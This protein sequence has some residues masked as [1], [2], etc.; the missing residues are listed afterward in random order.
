MY[1]LNLESSNLV[2]GSNALNTLYISPDDFVG[3]NSSSP[4]TEL[5]IEGG[6]DASLTS[7]GF[8]V[9]GGLTG[10]NIVMDSNEII[11]RSDGSAS[12]LFL[13]AT[14]GGVVISGSGGTTFDLLVNGT[15]AKPGGGSWTTT[16]DARLK[17]D[18]QPFTEG[19]SEVMQIEP[20]TYHYISQTGH[21]TS[22]EHVGVIAQDLQ[23]ISPSMVTE[24]EM[25]L[26]DGTKGNY[27]NIDPSAFT[28]ML[29]N[30]IQEL[31]TEN[32]QLT[33]QLQT[34]DKLYRE[35]LDAMKAQLKLIEHRLLSEP[36]R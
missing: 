13:N 7:H 2:L 19:L 17:Q 14:G 1:V 16:S 30:A 31:H 5:H 6:T 29:I 24:C 35:E 18:V 20:V 10:N 3:V 9:L 21:D 15:A 32:E 22:V 26:V 4:A 28:Y 27:L 23:K 8:M 12:D 11:A 36:L 34:Q 33:N 25:E